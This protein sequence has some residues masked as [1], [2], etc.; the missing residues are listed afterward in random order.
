MWMDWGSNL[1]QPFTVV[2]CA[3]IHYYPTRRY[4]HY[5]LDAGKAQSTGLADGNDH[6]VNDAQNHRNVMLYQH[7][8]AVLAT[9][10]GADAVRNGKHVITRADF[11]PRPKMFFGIFNG[12]SSYI[13]A[14]DNRNKYLKKGTVD[15]KTHRQ[16]VMGRRQNNISDNLASHMTMFEIRMFNSAVSI[17]VL[18]EIYKQLAATWKFNQYHV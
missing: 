10:Q 17:P 13:G 16:F 11:A 15:A 7:H 9:H 14:W 1:S 5:L 18:R 4:G 2:M 8:N 12:T 6:T 3:I